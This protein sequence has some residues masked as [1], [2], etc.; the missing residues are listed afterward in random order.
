MIEVIEV[1]QLWI[2][3]EIYSLMILLKERDKFV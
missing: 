3:Y 2:A 1:Y